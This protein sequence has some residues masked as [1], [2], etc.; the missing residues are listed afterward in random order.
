MVAGQIRQ[1]QTTAKR[2]PQTHRNAA[3]LQQPVHFGL[4]EPADGLVA[5]NAEL[6]QPAGFL[7]RV[8]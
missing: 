3:N 4:S 5:G 8:V 7:A 6:I 1:V 2:L